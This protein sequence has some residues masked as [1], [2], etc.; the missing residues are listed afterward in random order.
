MKVWKEVN[1]NTKEMGILSILFS[2]DESEIQFGLTTA[3]KLSE[4]AFHLS[5]DSQK[6]EKNHF[7]EE[8]YVQQKFFM[9]H[10][11]GRMQERMVD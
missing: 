3:K 4:V 5:A 11:M 9:V 7:V 8:S 6:T 1:T 10:T 2:I